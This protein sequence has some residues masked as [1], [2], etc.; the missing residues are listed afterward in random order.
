MEKTTEI[1]LSDLP[2]TIWSKLPFSIKTKK[3]V[4]LLSELPLEFQYLIEKYYDTKFPTITYD[5]A[6]DFK[7]DISNYSDL[8]VFYDTVDLL[9]EYLKNYLITRLKSYPFDPEFGCALKDQLM[10]SDTSLRQTYISNE[11][12]MVTSILS[13]DLSLNVRVV[14]F[15]I[16]RQ[17]GAASTEYICEIELSVDGDLLKMAVT[18]TAE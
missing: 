14:N 4:Y 15:K 12:Y 17:V 13:R 2:S 11:L 9:K 18:T 10:M 7:F 6:L 5:G 3:Q 8:G 1:K 16:S